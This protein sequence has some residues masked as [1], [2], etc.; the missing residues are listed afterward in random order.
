[1]LSVCYKKQSV[2]FII[3]CKKPYIASPVKEM[4]LSHLF[5]TVIIIILYFYFE[6]FINNTHGDNDVDKIYSLQCLRNVYS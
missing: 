6:I 5:E 1:M 2:F 3:S 4:T